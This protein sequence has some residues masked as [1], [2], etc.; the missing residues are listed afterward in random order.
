ME[1][2]QQKVKSLIE[3][4]DEIEKDIESLNEVLKSVMFHYRSEF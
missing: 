3:Q 4:K 2:L 1:N